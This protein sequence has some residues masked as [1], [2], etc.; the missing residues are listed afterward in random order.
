MQKALWV[1]YASGGLLIKNQGYSCCILT[2]ASCEGDAFPVP[3]R[4]GGAGSWHSSL[5]STLSCRVSSVFPTPSCSLSVFNVSCSPGCTQRDLLCLSIFIP[6]MT[7]GL[8]PLC[9]QHRPI[10]FVKCL[11]LLSIRLL[12]FLTD[13]LVSLFIVMCEMMNPLWD[14]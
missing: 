10:P 11:Y 2:C 14:L 8:T 9:I 6:L 3:C 12:D 1:R 7:D 4:R 5:L 13:F